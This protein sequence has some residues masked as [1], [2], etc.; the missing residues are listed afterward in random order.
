MKPASYI[1]E[2]DRD[3]YTLVGD[4]YTTPQ[5]NFNGWQLVEQTSRIGVYRKGGEYFIVLRG[6]D[7][8]D[9]NDLIDDARIGGFIDGEVTLVTQARAVVQRLLKSTTPDNIKVGGHSLGGYSAL[10]VGGE[11]S[12]QTVA[13]NPA[14]P[15]FRPT[16]L[17]PGPAK[18]RVYHMGGDPISTSV[19]PENAEVIR[20]DGGYGIGSAISAHSMKAF[21]ADQH[22]NG[23][24]TTDQEDLMLVAAAATWSYNNLKKYFPDLKAPPELY[25]IPPIFQLPLPG[26]SRTTNGDYCQMFTIKEA[27]CV[28]Y[29]KASSLD[30]EVRLIQYARGVEQ[31]GIGLGM[32]LRTI[33]GPSRLKVLNT[34]FSLGN[35]ALSFVKTGHLVLAGDG[36][37]IIGMVQVPDQI[38]ALQ[39]RYNAAKE[40][41]REY[42][43]YPYPKEDILAT[44]IK[45]SITEAQAA[46]KATLASCGIT[47]EVLANLAIAKK[48]PDPQARNAFLLGCAREKTTAALSELQNSRIMSSEI[49][50][51]TMDEAL[52]KPSALKRISDGAKNVGKKIIT[53]AAA[54]GK[55]ASTAVFDGLS[56]AGKIYFGVSKLFTGALHLLGVVGAVITV[57]QIAYSGYLAGEAAIT[58]NWEPVLAY[59]TGF[60]SNEWK[61][62]FSGANKAV[63]APPPQDYARP[64]T[65]NLRLK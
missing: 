34:T 64:E 5:K 52:A 8:K 56:V 53:K 58:G 7:V 57:I 10:A 29:S 22:I 36:A 33:L 26:A 15:V 1:R 61:M 14:A 55:I 30:Y 13:F 65:V 49:Q 9:P 18:A 54:A 20:V 35:Q 39:R 6:T 3:A 48:I 25:P 12:L 46:K 44:T 17:G 62:I 51:L 59:I 19:N 45:G 16:N 47:D 43:G 40:A 23:F 38:E 11:F 63:E 60:N 21:S 4:F 37:S 2:E 31:S 24:L 41:F 27:V 28:V 42:A 32:V 50:M